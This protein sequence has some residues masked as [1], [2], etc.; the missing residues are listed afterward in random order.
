MDPTVLP[1]TLEP[2]ASRSFRFETF[3]TDNFIVRFEIRKVEEKIPKE[4]KT[5][6]PLYALCQWCDNLERW[7]F[8]DHFKKFSNIYLSTHCLNSF[9]KHFE[10]N[11]G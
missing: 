10:P 7:P 2:L 6:S 11:Q 5:E 9:S 1:Y 8:G 4:V 3:Y